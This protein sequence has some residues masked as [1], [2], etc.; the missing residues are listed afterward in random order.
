MSKIFND[1]M[2]LQRFQ[3]N[4]LNPEQNEP[5]GAD[6]EFENEPGD[7]ETKEQAEDKM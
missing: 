5:D 7:G 3:I 6:L 2:A 1:L 4:L